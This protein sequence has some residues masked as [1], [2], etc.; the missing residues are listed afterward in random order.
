MVPRSVG[1]TPYRGCMQPV[2]PDCTEELASVLGIPIS[3][4]A[5]IF[6]V[7][8]S[9]SPEAPLHD[10]DADPSGG[11]E[12]P[13]TPWHLAGEPVQLMIRV[14]P[15]GVFLAIPDSDWARE[16]GDRY[17]PTHQQHVPVHEIDTHATAVLVADL[18]WRRRSTFRYCDYCRV[19]KA[20]EQRYD[21]RACC[22]MCAARWEGADVDELLF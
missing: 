2:V 21:D 20:P 10:Y 3:D 12:G 13:V 16:T 22:L 19:A 14:F 4:F 5:R 7:D 11:I 1:G 9:E 15:H 18:L 17:C 6:G 8:W